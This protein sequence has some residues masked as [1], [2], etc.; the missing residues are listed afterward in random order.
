MENTNTCSCS[1]NC[2]CGIN[3]FWVIVIVLIITGSISIGSIIA[4]LFWIFAIFAILFL[5][6]LPLAWYNSLPEKTEKQIIKSEKRWKL[7]HSIPE[8]IA[9]TCGLLFIGYLIFNYINHV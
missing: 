9:I 3:W 4:G 6:F 7:F 5:I 1:N 8:I 2:D